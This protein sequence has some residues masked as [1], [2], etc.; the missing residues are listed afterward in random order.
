MDVGSVAAKAVV[1]DAQSHAVLGRAILPTGWAPQEAGR[2]ALD[3]ALAAAQELA[4]QT[5]GEVLPA[6]SMVVGTGYG[7][8]ALP[9]AHKTLTEIACHARAAVALF[10]EAGVVLDIGGQDSKAISVEKGEHGGTVQ[11]FVMNDK[12]A[13]GTG[14]F[15]QMLSG[16][17]GMTLEQLGEAAREGRPVPISSMCAVF[18][19][20]E[21]VGLLARGTP[22]QDV[23]AGVFLSIARR[24]RALTGRIPLRGDCVFT[25]GLAQSPAF[26]ELLAAELGVPVR[27]PETPQC[28][29][30]LGAALAAATLLQKE[31]APRLAPGPLSQ[32]S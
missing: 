16:L 14:R 13:A 2:A 4:R 19:E 21:I 22:P 18:A 15:L 32:A 29:G 7:R 6:P 10:P 20:S 25:G 9:F 1:L 26:A 17:L 30:A 28:M 8:I 5:T 31:T 23:A 3:A 27:V 24:M 12:C 11:D